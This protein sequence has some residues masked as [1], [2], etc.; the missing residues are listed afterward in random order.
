MKPNPDVTKGARAERAAIVREIRN[1]MK[2]CCSLVGS[3]PTCTTY[4]TLLEWIAGRAK[5]TAKKPGGVGAR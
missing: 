1:A 4:A 3:C 5:R 2:E